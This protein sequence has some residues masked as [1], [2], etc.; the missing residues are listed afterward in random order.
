MDVVKDILSEYYLFFGIASVV[1]LFALIGYF[2]E[3]KSSGIKLSKT[4]ELKTI[5]I[6][7]QV[8]KLQNQ[9]TITPNNQTTVAP[10]EQT[11]VETLQPEVTTQS[12]PVQPT[13]TEQKNEENIEILG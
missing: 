2:I 4:E 13:A 3:R 6:Q 1:F 12:T 9:E 8:T 11:Q 5:N 10:Q 7:E